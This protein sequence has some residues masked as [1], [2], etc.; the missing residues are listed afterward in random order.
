ML[1]RKILS[2]QIKGFKFGV[3]A[4]NLTIG[5]PKEVFPNEKRVS[6]TPETVERMVKKHG[7]T[8]K[9]E[10]GAGKEAAYS[11]ELYEKSGARLVDVRE[12]LESDVVLKVRPPQFNEELGS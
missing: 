9:V 1:A 3:D 11:D 8:F 4:K 10:K 6:V 7:M 5:V 12:A 2:P